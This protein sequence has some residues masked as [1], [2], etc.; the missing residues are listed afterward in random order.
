VVYHYH[1]LPLRH[2]IV[3]VDPRSKTSPTHIFNQWRKRGVY[4]EEW[5]D[6]DFWRK[7]LKLLP[8]PDEA[9]LQEKRDR[10]RGRQKFFYKQCLIRLKEQG[11]TWV[12]LHDSDEYL[13]YNHPGG[14]KFAAWEKSRTEKHHGKEPRIKPSKTPPTTAQEGGMIQ[15][16]RQEQAAGL[17][18]YQS[19]CIGIPRLMFGA[20]ESKVD[21]QAILKGVP[22]ELQQLVPQMDTLKYRVHAKR[23]DF[24]K[25]ALGKVIMDVSRVDV[26]NS[27][28][29]MSLHRPIKS[30]CPTPWNNDWSSGLR[31]NHYLGS[32]DSYSFRD[33]SRRGGERSWEQW[34]YKATTIDELTDDIIRPWISGLVDTHGVDEAAAMLKDVGL[35]PNYKNP[36]DEAWHLHPDKLK[37]ILEVKETASTDAKLIAYEEWVR[38]KYKHNNPFQKKAN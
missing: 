5:G 17:E 36:D 29:F 21:Q 6:R 9:P 13:V 22:A 3:A 28:Y 8:I 31:I 32:W 27:P 30:I 20:D 26:K 1:V 34:E 38:E 35:P 12:S 4:I 33:D 16:I 23:N 18:Y 7:D 25:N 10:H 15:Y 24:T 2:M 14:D 19:P 37:A 11:R